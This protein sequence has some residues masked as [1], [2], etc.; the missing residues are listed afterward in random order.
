MILTLY[1]HNDA[2][3]QDDNALIYTAETVLSWFEDHEVNF[4][5]FPGQHN[6]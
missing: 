6:Y 1:P 2:V 4:S 5:I 3:F